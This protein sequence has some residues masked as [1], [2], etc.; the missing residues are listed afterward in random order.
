MPVK[1]RLQRFGRT[2]R[3]F[4]HVVVADSR[5]P[6]DGKFIEKLGSYNPVTVPA[7]IDI[8]VDRAVEWLNN[9]AQPTD[10]AERILS[11]TGVL[12]KRHLLRGVT[13]G[14]VPADQVEVK[15]N[16]FMEAAN[17]KSAM[18]RDAHQAKLAEAQRAAK[19][20]VAKPAPAAPAAEEVAP[21]A[22]AADEAPA[23]E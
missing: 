4:Y 16:A 23:A 6:R 12:Y 13:K 17:A 7:T 2:K 9:G 18:K 14:V 8:N 3:P 11:Y 1:I 20:P 22:P 21:E 5:S 15:W 19:T 10:T